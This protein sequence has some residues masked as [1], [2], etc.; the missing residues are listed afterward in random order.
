MK[1]PYLVA[2]AIVAL[3]LTAFADRPNY[4]Y[5]DVGYARQHLQSPDK[6]RRCNQDGVFVEG[7]LAKD[8]HIFFNMRHV[9][10]TSGSWC[11]STTTSGSLGWR[12]DYGSAS[13]FFGQA[14][15]IYQNAPRDSDIGVGATLGFRSIV[16]D[17]LEARGFAGWG[18]IDTEETYV[19]IGLNYQLSS[20]FSLVGD[21]RVNR[22]SNEDFSLGIR[23]NF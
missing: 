11:G 16:L 18:S 21:V 12:H 13:S 7:S 1:L 17:N 15:L 10:A 5:F 20:A 3:P 23:Y 14:T 19:G 6:Q 22:R 8:E 2:A 9:D 4:T